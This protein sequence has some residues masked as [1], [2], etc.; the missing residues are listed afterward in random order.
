MR[1]NIKINKLANHYLFVSELSQWNELICH[2]QRKKEW[3]KKTGRLSTKEKVA[4]E[5]FSKILKEAKKLF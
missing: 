4:L 5:N 2:P 1:F 3:I